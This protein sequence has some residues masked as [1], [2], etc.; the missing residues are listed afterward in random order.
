MMTDRPPTRS[1]VGS[2]GIIA[3]LN[4]GGAGV[5]VLNTILLFHFFD[6]RRA[7]EVC[8]AAGILRLAVTQLA[9]NGRISELLIPIYHKARTDHG[10]ER[11]RRVFAVIFNWSIICVAGAAGIAALAAPSLISL[12]VPGFGLEDKTLAVTMFRVLAPLVVVT[13]AQTEIRALANA[14]HSFAWPEGLFLLGS[15]A[16]LPVLVTC[17]HYYGVWA[18][19]LSWWV[20]SMVGLLGLV[21]MLYRMGYRHHAILREPG[22]SV[23][24]FLRKLSSTLGHTVSMLVYTFVQTAALSTLPQGI[25]AIF[26]YVE[27]ILAKT[28]TVAQRPVVVVFLTQVSQA[29]ARGERNI[30]SLVVPALSRTLAI[31]SIIVAG[32]SAA[33]H[34]LLVALWGYE[35][36]DQA[37]YELATLL[38]LVQ[39][40]LLTVSGLQLVSRQTLMALGLVHRVSWLMASAQLLSALCTWFF[41]VWW[42]TNGAIAAVVCNALLLMSA[43]LLLL[44]LRQR[45][46]PLWY[47]P[48]RVLCWTAAVVGGYGA[49]CAVRSLFPDG[50]IEYRLGALILGVVVAT[51]SMGVAL[52]IAWVLGIYEVRQAVTRTW[53][54]VT[55]IRKKGAIRA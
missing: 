27:R 40:L 6:T 39:Y 33:G 22:F 3:L 5:A 11:A 48:G 25:L 17:A 45:T 53:A 26:G 51:T 9:Q 34:A 7:L 41:V 19:V 52:G 49:G 47:P 28:H 44:L 21:V 15:A 37:G 43:P 23:R 2:I 50:F 1:A 20:G 42:G 24:D 55:S 8:F 4:V 16:A 32:Y 13:I 38:V 10:R 29:V 14:E 12:L 35:R 18:V 54:R 46:L 36:L 30:R 31:V